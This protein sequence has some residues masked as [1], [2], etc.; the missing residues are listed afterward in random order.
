MPAVCLCSQRG[1]CGCP[2]MGDFQE[3]KGEDVKEGIWGS[4]GIYGKIRS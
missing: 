4:F 2:C 1:A 3:I